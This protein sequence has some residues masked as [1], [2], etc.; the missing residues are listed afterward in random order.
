MRRERLL[1]LERPQ[2]REEMTS[3]LAVRVVPSA[4][5]AEVPRVGSDIHLGPDDVAGASAA[6]ALPPGR[7]RDLLDLDA[8]LA[9]ADDLYDGLEVGWVW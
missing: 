1:A 7:E 8:A 3:Q 4:A 9:E 5:V 6:F 2:R